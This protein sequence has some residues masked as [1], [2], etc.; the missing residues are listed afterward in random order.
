MVVLGDDDLRQGLYPYDGGSFVLHRR[1][2]HGD[3]TD[4]VVVNGVGEVVEMGLGVGGW[5]VIGVG[6]PF[7]MMMVMFVWLSVLRTGIGTL[8]IVVLFCSVLCHGLVGVSYEFGTSGV[9]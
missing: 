6:L 9:H 8:V 5:G 2:V 1:R 4:V 3:L 7:S